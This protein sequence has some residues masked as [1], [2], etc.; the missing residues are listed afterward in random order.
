MPPYSL[1]PYARSEPEVTAFIVLP[2]GLVALLAWGTLAAWQ[3]AGDPPARARRV[4][5]LVTLAA[6]AWMAVTWT[7]ASRGLLLDFSR[8][9]PPFGLLM[10]GVLL[11]SIAIAAG[12]LGRRLASHIPLW[13]L[14]LV[15]V[16]RVP[17]EIAMHRL[18]ERG[19]MPVQMS[20][21]GRNFDIVTG[22]TALIVAVLVWRGIGGRRLVLA[23]NLL[24][25]ALLVNIVTVAILSTPPF[26]RFGPDRVN[27]FVMVTPFVWL[28]AVLVVAALAG[29]LI[30][31]RALYGA[32]GLQTGRP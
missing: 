15:H 19:I 3:R 27:V 14:V 12:S 9:P 28:P 11:L 22:I 1:P 24:G 4:M 16:F 10:A 18:A 31:F 32:A 30:I 29:H 25:L 2:L 5:L 20:Y 8:T 6:A 26:A 21:A 17:L 7:A 13:A 23:W